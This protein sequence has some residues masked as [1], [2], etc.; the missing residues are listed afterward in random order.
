M[1]FTLT[2][3]HWVFSG[4]ALVVVALFV[5][6]AVREGRVSRDVVR[7][8][9]MRGVQAGF[10]RLYLER[11]S[12]APAAEDGCDEVGDVVSSCNVAAYLPD[13]E[14]LVDPG[15]HSYTVSTVPSE[16]TWEV[17]FTLEGAVGALAEGEHRV[18]PGGIQ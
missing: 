14:K 2:A 6:L 18:G 11:A 5:L 13:T 3:R 8:S 16:T 7:V 17:T 12:Y 4:L 15:A 9:A 10:T 1:S